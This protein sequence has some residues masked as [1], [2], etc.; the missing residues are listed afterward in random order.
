MTRN[1]WPLVD[2]SNSARDP[3]SECRPEF[4]AGSGGFHRPHCTKGVA[5]RPSEGSRGASAH[6][7]RRFS[8]PR[9]GTTPLPFSIPVPTTP[10][11]SPWRTKRGACDTRWRPGFLEAGDRRCRG[12]FAGRG[13][14]RSLGGK[15]G[16][17]PSLRDGKGVAGRLPGVETPGK[18]RT[19]ALRPAG[20]L[21]SRWERNG[22]GR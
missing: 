9:R 17:G 11:P 1:D 20:E 6:G 8:D 15:A 13:P 3:K 19:V 18:P 16:L 21:R 4:E 5:E 10:H 7:F 12:G 14:L 22:G 2:R